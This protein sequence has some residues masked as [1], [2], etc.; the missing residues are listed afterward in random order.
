ME[1]GDLGSGQ[2]AVELHASLTGDAHALIKDAFRLEPGAPDYVLV[3]DDL[4]AEDLG[5]YDLAPTGR[6][7]ATPMLLDRSVGGLVA[8]IEEAVDLTEPLASYF[9]QSIL[10][11]LVES[12]A[13]RKIKPEF[14]M[15][16]VVFV[17]LAGLSEAVDSHVLIYI[18]KELALDDEGRLLESFLDVAELE[19][20]VLGH[21]GRL[22]VR[23]AERFGP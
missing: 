6:R 2:P 18:H 22:I 20:K 19:L 11:L 23:F 15:L 7:A 13:R 17:N 3:V 9:P 10:N 21:V 14:P 16:T 5:E 12:V 8:S 1:V 4:S